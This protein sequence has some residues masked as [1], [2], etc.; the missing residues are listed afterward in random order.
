MKC[1]ID[2]DST[3]CRYIA[4]INKKRLLLRKNCSYK[5]YLLVPNLP[6]SEKMFALA[7]PIFISYLNENTGDLFN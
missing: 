6:D 1:G 7:S 3:Q 2:I 4:T 5:S